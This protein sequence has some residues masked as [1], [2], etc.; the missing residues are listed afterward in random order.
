MGKTTNLVYRKI[1]G[2]KP[3][4]RNPR[5]IKGEQFQKLKESIE[6][7]P[8][9]FEARPLILSDRTGDLVVIAGNQRLEA[10]KDLGLAEVP[11]VLLA[12]LSEDREKEIIIRDNVENGEWDFD[13]LANEWE[14]ADLQNWGVELKG[15]DLD[16][17]DLEDEQDKPKTQKTN[18]II[19]PNCGEEIDL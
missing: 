15:L 14:Q 11:T 17:S 6:R 7:N 10:A 2:L 4:S 9:Y 18:K 8:D 3:L 5:Q 12:G 16:F 1:S 13:M 19:C